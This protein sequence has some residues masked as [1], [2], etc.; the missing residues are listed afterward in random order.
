[1]HV[2]YVIYYTDSYDICGTNFYFN[3]INQ[4]SAKYYQIVVKT[5]NVDFI[6]LRL[7][8]SQEVF[9]EQTIKGAE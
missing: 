5:L 3:V 4:D 6:A 7:Y 9:L 8:D 1:M 2:K